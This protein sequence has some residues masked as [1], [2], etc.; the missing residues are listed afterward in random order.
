[1]L[2]ANLR[3]DYVRT[4]YKPLAAS[5]FTEIA[6]VF[7]EMIAGGRRLLIEE[8][9]IPEAVHV[10]RFLD[11]R[12]P[13]QEFPIQ[14]PVGSEV[15]ATADIA[16]MRAS[17][18]EL[19][20]RRYGHQAVDEP[21]EIVNLR[22]TVTGRRERAHFA[23][24]TSGDGDAEIARSEVVLGDANVPVECSIYDRDLLGP[25]A[26]VRGPAIVW[27]YASTT[28]LFEGDELTVAES[29]ELLIRIGGQTA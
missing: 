25:G 29:G 22:V 2:M 11:L 13:G 3:H 6:G 10:Q 9:T 28:V 12:Y 16:S 26:T 15:V 21:I 1:M 14:T 5:D 8:G 20:D 27:E 4:Y 23:R 19:H 7:D 24:L 18:D 17:F